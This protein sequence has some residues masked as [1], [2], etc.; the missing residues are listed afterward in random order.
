VTSLAH[1]AVLEQLGPGRWFA[2]C[3]ALAE[4]VRPGGGTVDGKRQTGSEMRWSMPPWTS[5]DTDRCSGLVVQDSSDSG[6][7]SAP[8]RSSG[9]PLAASGPAEHTDVSR[10]ASGMVDTAAE[11]EL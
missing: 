9:G 2:A 11:S 7:A 4:V 5:S 8:L 1:R 6:A 3:D 10:G